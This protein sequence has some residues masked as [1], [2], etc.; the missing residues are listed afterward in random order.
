MQLCYSA[1]CSDLNY[2]PGYHD[3]AVVVARL[4]M[5][6][7]LLV[8]A[9]LLGTTLV[10]VVVAPMAGLLVVV[11][12]VPVCWLPLWHSGGLWGL[13]GGPKQGF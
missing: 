11:L 13:S 12:V 5:L 8:L 1:L 9:G 4:L 10:V 7:R 3:C 2:D 6:A